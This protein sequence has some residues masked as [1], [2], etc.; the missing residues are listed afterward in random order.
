MDNLTAIS[1]TAA[2]A[3]HAQSERLRMISENMANADSI[4]APGEETYRRKV[5]VFENMV[6][7]ETGANVVSVRAVTDDKTPLQLEYN[8]SHPSA[9]ENGYVERPNVEPLIEMANMREAA[10][11]YE[12]NLNMLTTGQSMRQQ[13]VDLL[14]Q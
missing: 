5:P 12:A 9:N 3:L 14:N 8:P 11:S 4:A 2:S 13:L 7:S 6:D 1:K 10:R